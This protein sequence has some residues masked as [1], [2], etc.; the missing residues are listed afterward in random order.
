MRGPITA[1]TCLAFSSLAAGADMTGERLAYIV[2]CINCH[3]QTPKEI[4]ASPPLAIVQ[5]YS[6]P[7]FRV[8][9]ESGVTRGGRN[10][11]AESS[12]MGI[13]AMEQFS[14]LTDD[15]VAALYQF[16]HDDW[17]TQRAAMEEAKIPTL[18]K[19]SGTS[20]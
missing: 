15:E 8:L 5:V 17:T 4:M 6:L 20:N 18:Y 2:G 3:H 19:S 14:H 7:E 13:V 11:L 9:L 12:V 1:L 10:L 16:L